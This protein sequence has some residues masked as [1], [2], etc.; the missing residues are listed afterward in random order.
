MKLTPKR[1]LE[2]Q[3]T[4]L[5]IGPDAVIGVTTIHTFSRHTVAGTQSYFDHEPDVATGL[6][7]FHI[8]AV[9]KIL[10]GSSEG[11][12]AGEGMVQ[13]AFDDRLVRFFVLPVSDKPDKE[14]LMRLLRWH[15]EKVLPSNSEYEFAAK[16]GKTRDGYKVFGAAINKATM[17]TLG[18]CFNAFECPWSVADSTT[19]FAWN[20]LDNE[21]RDH[22]AAWVRF[23]K[24]GWSVIAWEDD[25]NIAFIKTARWQNADES[26]AVVR[27]GMI[28][29]ARLLA[30]YADKRGGTGFNKVYI[31]PGNFD[32]EPDQYDK[33][34]TAETT[35]IMNSTPVPRSVVVSSEDY[36]MEY[37]AAYLASFP[38]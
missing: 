3:C 16:L 27:E 6:S 13:V 33:V 19:G 23:G 36:A 28:E 1:L 34:F 37:R 24:Q 20:A 25:G 14:G 15:A 32:L 5:Y 2:N 18:E 12:R 29:A 10:A 8:K 30:I 38:R 26:G 17:N 22:A 35:E 4:G 9:N 7:D 21:I 11:V 31:E